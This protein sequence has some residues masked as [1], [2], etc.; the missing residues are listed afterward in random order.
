M[1]P[2]NV[3][4]VVCDERSTSYVKK[5]IPEATRKTAPKTQDDEAT[6]VSSKTR[7]R[8]PYS[9][10]T[11]SH[12]HHTPVS[13]GVWRRPDTRDVITSATTQYER[14]SDK[15]NFGGSVCATGRT[16]ARKKDTCGR[17]CLETFLT[18]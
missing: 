11:V 16:L 7:L 14:T 8:E 3:V 10:A 17:L 12:T 6:A 15:V 13:V 1:I 5:L 4:V 9:I 2:V 18:L